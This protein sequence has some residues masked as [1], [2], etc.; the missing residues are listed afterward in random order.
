MHS[1]TTLCAKAKAGLALL[2]ASLAVQMTAAIGQTNAGPTANGP[3]MVS[4]FA[5]PPAGLTNPDSI[6]EGQGDIFVTYANAT[7]PDGSGGTSTVVQYSPT[8]KMI[9]TYAIVGKNDGLK[10]DPATRRVW[11][12]RNQDANP[13]LTII[14]P[15]TGRLLSTTPFS[16]LR[17]GA[18]SWSS[19]V[20]AIRFTRLRVTPFSLGA[21]TQ[22]ATAMEYS[23][24]SI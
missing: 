3:Y 21:L 12:L 6:T 13:A 11:A 4:V 7:Q 16:R 14:D 10:Y 1:L 20:P 8:A 19:T 24:K 9:R 2:S 18:R 23:A 17:P 5:P 15:K 22:L